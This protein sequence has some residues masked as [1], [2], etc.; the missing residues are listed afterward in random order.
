MTE[1]RL[2][3][4]RTIHRVA[5][6]APLLCTLLLGG[7]G[8]WFGET[9][10][11]PLKGERLSV[12][13]H[14]RQVLPDP[15]LENHQIL[16]PPP[17]TNKNW[18]QTGGYANHAMQHLWVND[19]LQRAWAIDVGAAPDTSQPLLPAPVVAEGRVFTMDAEHTVSAFDAQTG[20]WVWEAELAPDD[21][22]DL[23]PGGLAFE[24]G[25]I[26][27]TTG[28]AEVVALDAASGAEV[29][30][31]RVEAPLHAPPTVRDGRVFAITVT[32]TLYALDAENG[33]QLWTFRAI[34]ETAALI[35]GANPAVEGDII[36]APFSSGEL[37]A[38]QVATGQ[39]LWSDSFA[40]TRRTDEIASIAQIRGVPT[41]D[42]GRVFAMSFGGLIA[43]FD[44]RTGR[45]LWDRDIG[46]TQTP[47][48]AGDYIY[49][50]SKSHELVCLN[51]DSGRV[52][53]ISQLPAFEDEE[54]QE[55]PI[56]W[57]G[58]VLAGDRLIAVGS[59]EE[60]LTLSPY[61]GEFLGRLEMAAPVSVAPVV[62]NG[63]IFVLGDDARLSVF[64]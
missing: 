5:T 50:I 45:R 58:P 31:T 46:G 41:I 23:I 48:I 12:M 51:R 17:V 8:V 30:N 35:G 29:W 14:E 49:V 60:V 2:V 4:G 40:S 19:D 55:D 28:F 62:A 11:P 32:N 22:E 53:W 16:L 1:S 36:V 39:V 21:E 25:R 64:R 61:T 15:S 37:V 33:A 59:N 56:I 54:D 7:C 44:L 24:D 26:F 63:G 38:L 27:V 18:P 42:R 13:V 9:G 20:D 34:A 52:H 6:A 47:W 3:L 57:A 10:D 43:S